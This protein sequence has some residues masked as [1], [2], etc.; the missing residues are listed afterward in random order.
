MG[1]SEQSDAPYFFGASFSVGAIAK[2]RTAAY[3]LT[4]SVKSACW[5]GCEVPDHFSGAMNFNDSNGLR[6]RPTGRIWPAEWPCACTI[7]K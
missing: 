4:L 3:G 5:R 1:A 7:G 6:D 2:Y